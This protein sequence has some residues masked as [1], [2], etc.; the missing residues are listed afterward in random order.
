MRSAKVG[1]VILDRP[2]PTV[3]QLGEQHGADHAFALLEETGHREDRVDV[4]FGRRSKSTRPLAIEALNPL[5]HLAEHP[6][7][8]AVRASSFDGRAR[9]VMVYATSAHRVSSTT[10][11]SA[12]PGLRPRSRQSFQIRASRSW[13]AVASLLSSGL[14]ATAQTRPS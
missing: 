13:L 11:A 4:L 3:L 10:A 8:R 1:R 6:G 2:S 5:R 9:D 14:K 12:G 7:S